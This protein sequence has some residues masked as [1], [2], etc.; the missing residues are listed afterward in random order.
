[1][2]L[3]QSNKEI[4]LKIGLFGAGNVGGALCEAWSKAGHE[5]FFGVKDP[6]AKTRW[7]WVAR[8]GPKA[9][10]GSLK[11]A[12]AFG[13]LIVIAL[14]WQAAFEA[15]PGLNLGGK[16]VIDYSNPPAAL[17]EGTRSGVQ[18]LASRA[19]A[20]KFAKAFNITGAGNMANP[21]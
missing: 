1:M 19:P 21:A 13:E 12:G 10:A 20:A 18:A 15:L 14:P 7:R 8:C 11:E 9:R 16:V 5:V 4:A 2:A 17:P 3:R 6:E